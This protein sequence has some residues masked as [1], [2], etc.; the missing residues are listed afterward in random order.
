MPRVA[1]VYTDENDSMDSEDVIRERPNSLVTSRHAKK[2][3][4]LFP[5]KKDRDFILESI[6]EEEDEQD[7]LD[8][9]ND[10]D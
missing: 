5:T 7:L 10:P 4:A 9:C 8:K 2:A 1:L 3:Y 6:R